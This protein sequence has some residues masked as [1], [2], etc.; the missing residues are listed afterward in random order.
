MIPSFTLLLY[1]KDIQLAIIYSYVT[2]CMARPKAIAEQYILYCRATRTILDIALL[3]RQHKIYYSVMA[4]DLPTQSVIFT[5]Y[6]MY[7]HEYLP[8]I[9]TLNPRALG[10]TQSKADH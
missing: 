2:L 5:S 6:T 9:Y 4:F 1:I 7:G 10:A 3:A 8:D